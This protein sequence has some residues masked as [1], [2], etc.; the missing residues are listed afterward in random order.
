MGMDN[1]QESSSRLGPTPQGSKRLRRFS[2]AS[3]HSNKRQATS[4]AKVAE[5]LIL[6]EVICSQQRSG[7]DNHREKS[8]FRDAL[9]STR[10][11]AR[12]PHFGARR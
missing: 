5:Y 3:Q 12:P 9:P 11:T 4:G 6:H 8:I 10:M 2:D 1:P 7:H